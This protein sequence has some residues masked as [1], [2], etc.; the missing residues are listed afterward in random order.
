ML[1]NGLKS[2]L[3]KVD[4][5]ELLTVQIDYITQNGYVENTSELLK[6]PF[7][8]PAS[9]IRLFD[10]V[11]QKRIVELLDQVKNNALVANM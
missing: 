3:Y 4:K 8:K 10:K 9:F 6:P 7:D 1:K 11:D 5:G 2:R